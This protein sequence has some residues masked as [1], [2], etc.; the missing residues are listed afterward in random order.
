MSKWIR[1]GDKV[2]VKSGNEKGRSGTVRSRKGDR[3]VIEGLNL[4]KKHVKPKSRV[5]QGIVEI[6]VPIHVSN[7]SLSDESGKPVKVKVK[8]N[9]EGERQLVYL[10]GD[11]EVF[12]RNVKQSSA[13]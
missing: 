7:L 8:M 1:K 12:Y 2:V 13:K 6:E 5:A 3:V 11:K 10:Q 4:R 9:K